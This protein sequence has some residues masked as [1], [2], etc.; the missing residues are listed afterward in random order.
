MAVLVTGGAGYIGSHTALALCDRGEKVVV[1]DDLSS[2]FDWAVPPAADLVVGDVSDQ[3]LVSQLIVEHGITEIVHF[4]ARIL[5]QESVG[6]PLRYY[7]GNTVKTR[8][9]LETALAH[10]VTRLIFSST[11]AVYGEAQVEIIPEDQPTAP[12]NPYGRSKLMSE[13]MLADVARAHGLAYVVL[14]YFNVAGADPAGRAGETRRVATHLV[15]VASEA[16][17][18]VR[19]G[20]EIFGTDYPTR[21]G[22]CIRDYVHVSDLASAHVAALDHLRAGGANLTLNCGYGRGFSVKEVVDVVKRVSGVDFPVKLSGRRAGDPA[23]LVGAA[24]R[25][26]TELGWT[27]QLDDLETIVRHALGWEERL[28]SRNARVK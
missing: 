20:V 11:A 8:A 25:I 2:G 1:L 18:G 6:D 15:K 24:D 21:D 4:A 14:R 13:W 3:A 16:A 17:S 12:I 28:A 5:V 26:R 19:P 9:L 22:S 10:G 27:P 23:C 7:L